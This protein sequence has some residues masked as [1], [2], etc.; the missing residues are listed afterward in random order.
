MTIRTI[1]GTPEWRAD[2]DRAAQRDPAVAQKLAELDARLAELQGQPRNPGAPPPTVAPQTAPAQESAGGGSG[3]VFLVLFLG[4]GVFVLLWLRRRRTARATPASPAAR[5]TRFRVGMTIP[6]DPAPFLLAAGTTK[7]RPPEGGGW[8]ASRR[9]AVL[10]TARSRCIGCTCRA[11]EAFFQ[12]CISA[13]DG[14]ARRVP[15]LLA[16]LTR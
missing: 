10:P 4:A 9:W 2:A 16:D 8:S 5:Q 15:L 7:V 11:G 3:L 6:V 14:H 1:R 13:P 12:L